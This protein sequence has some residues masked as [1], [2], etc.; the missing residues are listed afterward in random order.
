V[1]KKVVGKRLFFQKSNLEHF[2][3]SPFF[4]ILHFFFFCKKVFSAFYYLVFSVFPEIPKILFRKIKKN[5][6]KEYI[7]Y[8]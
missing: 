3:A 1:K 8:T 7:K 2:A 5:K 6:K 4:H